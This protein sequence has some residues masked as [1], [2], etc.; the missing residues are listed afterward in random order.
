T[1]STGRPDGRLRRLQAE[2]DRLALAAGAQAVE[3]PGLRVTLDDSPLSLGDPALPEDTRPDDLVVHQHD[4]QAVVN[5]LWV[6]GAE[7]VQL[8]DQRVIATSAVR[9]VGPVLILQ[10]RVYPPPY[11][12]TA[13]GPVGRMRASLERSPGVATYRDYVALVGL[14]YDVEDA[15]AVTVPAYDGP[16]ELV[17]ARA[18]APG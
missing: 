8:M 5:A 12:V 7:A 13:I 16:L 1:R 4:L 3:G 9:C 14:R 2:A 11:V 15:R 18:G 17:H 6:G 10:G